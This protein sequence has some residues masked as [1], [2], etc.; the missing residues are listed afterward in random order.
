M[1]IRII[2]E[3]AVLL[4]AALCAAISCIFVPFDAQYADY[5]DWGVIVELF[6]LMAVVC[7][8]R[9]CGLL[10]WLAQHMLQGR[11]TQKSV[12]LILVIM[13]FF[14]SMFV[15]NDVALIAFVPFSFLVLK[16]MN[17]EDLLIKTIV[18]QT[19]AANLGSMAT[20]V[21]NPQ[22]LFLYAHFTMSTADFFGIMLPLSV[23]SLFLLVVCCVCCKNK[24]VK[25]QFGE[26]AH[27]THIPQLYANI[28]LFL[29]CLLTVFRLMP[30][31]ALL[32]IVLFWFLFFERHLL[33][34]V[35]YALLLTFICFFV[36][37]GN[38]SRIPQVYDMLAAMLDK[39]T[40]LCSAAASQFISNVP[41]AVLLADMTSDWQGLLAGVNIGGLGTPVASL[42]SLIS[43]KFYLHHHSAKPKQYLF[44]FSLANLIGL[45]I[46]L[47]FA[48]FCII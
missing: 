18:L 47:L 32:L 35:D 21:G 28:F 23:L 31:D 10:E 46:L 33:L 36:L 29:L 14:I 37:S 34:K 5:I 13:T 2:K 24:Q 3:E 9:E 15:T 1:I 40:L 30:Y 7:G 44:W 16:L 6:C 41:A 26:K 25:I 27:L 38:L 17:A 45:L 8:M 12:V 4:I 43:L 22:N 48:K 20:P 11:K 42:A 39:S 19:I